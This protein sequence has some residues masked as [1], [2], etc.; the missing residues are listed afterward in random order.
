MT[1]WCFVAAIILGGASI[2]MGAS[3]DSL[4]IA[5]FNVENLT[6]NEQPE[7]VRALA[8]FVVRLDADVI[9]LN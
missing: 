7:R 2:A 6:V 1:R 4:R 5:T 8:D 9:L 3:N